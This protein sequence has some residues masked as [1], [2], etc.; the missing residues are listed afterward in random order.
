MTRDNSPCRTAINRRSI[1]FVSTTPEFWRIASAPRQGGFFEGERNVVVLTWRMFQRGS[2]AMLVRW[3]ACEWT[4]SRPRLSGYCR[5][6]LFLPP[7]GGISGTGG[8]GAFAEHH[9]PE[10]GRAAGILIL[11]VVAN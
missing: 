3:T 10:Y 5:R 1:A 7:A 2:E 8:G 9:R 4:G 11:F 6:F